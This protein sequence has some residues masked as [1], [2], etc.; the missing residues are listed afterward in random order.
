VLLRVLVCKYWCC[1]FRR[2]SQIFFLCVDL[3]FSGREIRLY[4]N[5]NKVNI[6]YSL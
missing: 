6:N 1:C 5:G 4:K 3:C 2:E